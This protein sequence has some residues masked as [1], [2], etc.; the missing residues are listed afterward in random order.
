M[1]VLMMGALAGVM[2][3]AAGSV[4]AQE[5]PQ[6]SKY[7]DNWD[8]KV[9]VGARYGAAFPGSGETKVG[10]MPLVEATRDD[11]K[12]FVGTRK[13]VGMNVV[14]TETTKAGVALTYVKGRD[15]DDDD[16][17]NGI[18]DIDAAA[19]ARVFGEYAVTPA[20]RVNG[21]V[22]QELGG[23]NGM[24]ATV[25]V[26]TMRP[27]NEKLRL[28]AGVDTT[29]ASGKHMR[30]WYG[31]SAVQSGASGLSQFK[32]ESGLRDVTANVGADYAVTDRLSANVG[33]SMGM[34]L[35]DAADSPVSKKNVVPGIFAGL[36]WA[37]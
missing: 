8:V 16:R 24:T 2:V 32:A 31:V 10:A 34:L 26:G 15:S 14:N 20:V 35:G 17:L 3:V 19:G 21:H 33:A 13:G 22:Q 11:G 37:F 27:V 7:F 1:K 25:G 9:G 28:R 36:T 5:G 4:V 23:S 18:Q 6:A 29:Y 12:Y 30:E